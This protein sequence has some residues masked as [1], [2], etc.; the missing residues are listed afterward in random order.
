MGL[1]VYGFMGL[2]VYGFMGLWV[3]GFMGLWVYGFMGLWVYGFMGLGF[4]GLGFNSTLL[5]SLPCSTL[6]HLYPTQSS[7]NRN[8]TKSLAQTAVSFV[9]LS[10]KS[11]HKSLCK[12]KKTYTLN[13]KH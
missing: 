11:K 4:R 9:S 12:N 5:P 6:L 8:K 13:P 1:W 3:Y 10:Q 2:W 7:G